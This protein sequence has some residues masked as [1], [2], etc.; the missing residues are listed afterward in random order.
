MAIGVLYVFM[1]GLV[2]VGA[3]GAATGGEVRLGLAVHD[4]E[5]R[6]QI[7]TYS[8]EKLGAPRERS[9]N[10]SILT[11]F[12]ASKSQNRTLVTNFKSCRLNNRVFQQNRPEADIGEMNLTPFP[13]A[14][15]AVNMTELVF[16]FIQ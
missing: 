2:F 1:L 11:K 10:S 15:Q 16:S 3:T 4:F 14:I 9:K 8:V 7:S 6:R 13:T 5:C 12:R